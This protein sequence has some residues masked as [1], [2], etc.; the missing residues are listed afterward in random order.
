MMTPE[1]TLHMLMYCKRARLL[2][3][4]HSSYTRSYTIL[5][6]LRLASYS[7]VL[8][9]YA[10]MSDFLKLAWLRVVER[11]EQYLLSNVFKALYF[12]EWPSYLR[13]NTRNTTRTPR[14]SLSSSYVAV[15]ISI[16]YLP[17]HVF[18]MLPHHIRNS[19]LAISRVVDKSP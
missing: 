6:L 10:T 5:Q 1:L 3:F 7:Y 17:R 11:K 4:L 19:N 2:S 9:R 18:N 13:V 15:A 8:G 12:E 16:R 14:S